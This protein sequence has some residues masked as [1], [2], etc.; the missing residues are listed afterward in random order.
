M[1]RPDDIINLL[2]RYRFRST[3]DPAIRHRILRSKKRT[4]ALILGSETKASPFIS[5]IVSLYYR[6]RSLG[7]GATLRGSAR[8]MSGA[9][10]FVLVLVVVSAALTL[11]YT[12]FDRGPLVIAR[13]VVTFKAGSAILS[14]EGETDREAAIGDIVSGGITVA[15]GA[16]SHLNIQLGDTAVFSIQPYSRVRLSS[17]FEKGAALLDLEEGSLLSRL[18]ALRGRSSYSIRTRNCYAAVRGTEFSVAY[19]GAATT[20]AVKEGTVM[21]SRLD[22]RSGKMLEQ[23]Q[24][25]A[26]YTAVI[27]DTLEV[28]PVSGL[29][30]LELE[31]VSVTPY[32]SD[33]EEMDREELGEEAKLQE[34]REEDIQKKIN[35][36]L[37]ILT[38]E[39]IREKY[40]QV[41]EIC[42]HNGRIYLGAILSRGDIFTIRTTH[43]IVR[44]P[45]AKIMK[46][47]AR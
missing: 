10:A 21:V 7:I 23:R 15:T 1:S 19:D 17:L 40:G 20:V 38:I 5:P 36:E 30:T 42:L 29:E 33:V 46:T 13:G 32:L 47:R 16:M 25:G 44:V 26:G 28:R 43:G 8:L 24:I 35:A 2:E 31:R 9:A 34:E 6:L 41:H 3:I 12:V 27:R 37:G 18:K 4:H 45:A 11:R 39:E 22:A 14:S